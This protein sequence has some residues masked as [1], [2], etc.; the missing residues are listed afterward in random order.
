MDGDAVQRF[1]A[2]HG[3]DT[4]AG[5]STRAVRGTLAYLV[6]VAACGRS[7]TMRCSRLSP[8]P[9]TNV[10]AAVALQVLIPTGWGGY[11]QREVFHKM[12]DF[13]TF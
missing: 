2:H 12:T 4:Q 5:V 1:R 9:L 11:M 8:A 10:A 6:V 3:R 7:A 13:M